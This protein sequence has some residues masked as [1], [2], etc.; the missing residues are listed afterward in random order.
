MGHLLGEILD[1]IFISKIEFPSQANIATAHQSQFFA[2]QKNH[3]IFL[4]F[5]KGSICTLIGDNKLPS[6]MLD[7]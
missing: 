2:T 1:K 7:F 6:S 3:L 4:R 5:N